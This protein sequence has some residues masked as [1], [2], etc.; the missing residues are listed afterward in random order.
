MIASLL[1]VILFS[2][3]YKK[4]IVI[5]VSECNV[6]TATLQNKKSLQLF[7]FSVGFWLTL[8]VKDSYC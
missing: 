1:S 8:F 6:S 5:R 3:N 4:C 2:K 7:L